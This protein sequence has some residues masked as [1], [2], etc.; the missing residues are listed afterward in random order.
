MDE[1]REVDIVYTEVS[2]VFSTVSH[3][4]FIVKLLMYELNE[5]TVRW[6]EKCL[7]GWPRGWRLMTRASDLSVAPH[8][9]S[10]GSSTVQQLLW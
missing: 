3:K 5:Q 7:N 4:S 1:G 9:V 10:D 6:T 8:G 2:E